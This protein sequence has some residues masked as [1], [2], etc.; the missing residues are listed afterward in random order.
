M[1]KLML[2]LLVPLLA[3]TQNPG[4]R[5]LATSGN[6]SVTTSYAITVQQPATNASQVYVD[7]AVAYCSAA[8]TVQ[9]FAN[10]TAATTT[11]GTV[12]P[13]L[14]TPLN[15]IAP[16]TFW[17]ASNV[18]TGTAQSGILN[19]PAGATSPTLCFTPSCGNPTQVA[20]GTG[21]TS[22]NFTILVTMATG[23]ANVALY[24]RSQ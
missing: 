17:T 20:L 18:G 7:Q 22:A 5:W 1:K 8:C 13:L 11:A 3:E 15:T 23:T 16:F 6:V 12:I 19:L 2:L 4:G 21:G 24:L 9:A 10:G 14:P